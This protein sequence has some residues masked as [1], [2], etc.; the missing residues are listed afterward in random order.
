MYTNI[1]VSESLK[2]CKEALD[3]TDNKPELNEFIIKL[4]ELVLT[5]N[6][7]EFNG[8]LFKQ[9]I[10]V[11][12]GQKPAPDVANIV[13][14]AVDVLIKNCAKKLFTTKVTIKFYKRFLDDIFM[15][16]R[17]SCSDLH[18]FLG[19]KSLTSHSEVHIRTYEN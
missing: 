1:P 18:K 11:A 7:F 17:G 6:I 9:E 2:L 3:T 13:M 4:L 5:L 16:I 12:M 14:A 8:E 15:L 19:G 10:G